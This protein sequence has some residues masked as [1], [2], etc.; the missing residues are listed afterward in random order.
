M[1]KEDEANDQKDE[2][3]E[4]LSP[5]DVIKFASQISQG[6]VRHFEVKYETRKTVFDHI[7][8]HL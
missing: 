8:K 6:M 5:K 2:S 1:S 7:S 4:T 3:E